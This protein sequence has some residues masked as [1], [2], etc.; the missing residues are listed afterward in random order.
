[1][2]TGYTEKK[3]VQIYIVTHDGKLW[4]LRRCSKHSIGRWEIPT[5]KCD[6]GESF[7][8]AAQRELREET[9]LVLPLDRFAYQCTVTTPSVDERDVVWTIET[10]GVVL[11]PEETP[12]LKEPHN[13]D[14]LQKF[15]NSEVT[16]LPKTMTFAISESIRKIWINQNDYV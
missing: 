10:Y 5:G 2:T 8:D 11:S 12:V 4:L 7:L 6:H 14:L 9:G 13:H 16:L 15:D 3:G 1:M